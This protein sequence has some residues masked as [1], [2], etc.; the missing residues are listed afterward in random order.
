MSRDQQLHRHLTASEL[1]AALEPELLERLEARLEQV[2]LADNEVLVSQGDVGHALYVLISGELE[3]RVRTAGGSAVTVDRLGPGASVGE[4]ALVVGQERTATVVASGHAELVRLAREDFEK[5]AEVY[6]RLREELVRQMEPRL[7]RIQLGAIINTWFSALTP[8]EVHELQ[9]AVEWVRTGAGET[10]YRQGDA[11]DGMFLLV[12][13][14]LRVTRTGSDGEGFPLGEIGRGGSVG[15]YGVLSDAPRGETVTALRDSHLVKLDRQ[16]I[17]R[18]PSV[19]AQIARTALSRLQSGQAG[20][21]LGR[22]DERAEAVRTF[23]VVPAH[24]GAPA[25]QVA[26][27]LRDRLQEWGRVLAVDAAAVND[28]FAREG[29]AQ[30]PRGDP[31]DPALTYWLNEREAGHDYMIIE[32]DATPGPWTRR[33][34]RQA[35]VVLVVADAGGPVEGGPV[36]RMLAERPQGVAQLVLVHPDATGLPSGTARWIEAREPITHHHLR[37][38]VPGDVGRLARRLT[39]RAVG[40]V[41]S[42][43]GARGYV[44]IGLI[45]AIEELGIEIDMVAGTSMGALVGGAYALSREYEFCYRSAATFGDPKKLIDRTLPMVA[46]AKSRNVTEML[47]TM[48]GDNQIEDMWLPFACVSANLTRAV[49]VVDQHGPLWQA[50]RASTAIPGVFT[51]VVVDGDVLVDGG[52]MNNYP[53]DVMREE[54]R[55]GTVIG[56]NAAA[57][58]TK[59]QSYE[60]GPSVS[61]WRVL[62]QRLRPS[63]QR[64][65]YPSI[66]GTMMRATSVNSKHQGAAADAL[67]DL[68]VRYPVQEFGNLE[69][70]RYDALIDIGYRAGMESLAAWAPAAS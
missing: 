68:V 49:P 24:A 13:G 59:R 50:V 36:E 7:Q 53:V 58:E 62:L 16:L 1:F 40:L 48:F 56:S 10:L 21:G 35:D 42:G 17:A 61:G 31:L 23:A 57:Q 27:A 69:F 41:L 37:L 20:R 2:T 8:A 3:V 28:Q 12:S 34:L 22:G 47:R 9:R 39:G 18:H 30:T 45:K 33:S 5:V 60:F 4:M 63:R 55:A 70:D 25:S 11:A 67:A 44:H 15:E 14:R 26:R 66:I 46:L 51:P 64:A 29:V 54:L 38:G 52:V 19:I 6:P 65:R 32:A 43:G